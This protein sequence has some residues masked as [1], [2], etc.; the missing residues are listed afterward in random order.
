MLKKMP[1]YQKEIAKYSLHLHLAED[2]MN[3]YTGYV[4]KLCPVEQDLATGVD[5]EGERIKD[6]MRNIVP[7]LLDAQVRWFLG[8][9]PKVPMSWRTQG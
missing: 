7:I 8:S 3:K 2:C 4:E 9:G 1:Q 6:H 5:A